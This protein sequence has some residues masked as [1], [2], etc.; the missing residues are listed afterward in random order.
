MFVTTRDHI[1][2]NLGVRCINSDL[3]MELMELR[4]CRNRFS[5]RGSE[6][7]PIVVHA[8][9]THLIDVNGKSWTARRGRSD[10]FRVGRVE[11]VV[12]VTAVDWTGGRERGGRTLGESVLRK[13]KDDLRRRR[14]RRRSGWSPMSSFA[15]RE[16]RR[17]GARRPRN[18]R[19]ALQDR[20]GHPVQRNKSRVQPQ[21]KAR[22]QKQRGLLGIPVELPAFVDPKD[23]VNISTSPVSLVEDNFIMSLSSPITLLHAEI[24][25]V[26]TGRRC[27]LRT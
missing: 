15:T 23:Q 26:L 1:R 5:V 14:I 13:R 3:P 6:A 16:R 4:R 18:F 9:E 20:T 12:R 24:Q 2:A 19:F 21:P 17:I 25:V 27:V 8:R 7:V 11:S 10:T 22:K